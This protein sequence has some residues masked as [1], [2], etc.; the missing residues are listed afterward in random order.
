VPAQI[1]IAENIELKEQGKV[2]GSHFAWSHLWWAIGYPIAGFAGIYFN[3]HEFII[4]GFFSLLL[5]GIL[6]VYRKVK[7]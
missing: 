5:L 7:K 1:L 3:R 6:C 4:G 2:N